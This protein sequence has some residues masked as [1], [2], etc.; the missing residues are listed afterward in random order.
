VIVGEL[1][2]IQ[3]TIE[4]DDDLVVHG[5]VEGT[6]RVGGAITV[7]PGAWVLAEVS[8]REVIV[9]GTVRGNVSAR[10]G[11][12]VTRT[13]RMIGDATAPRVTIAA[14]AGFRGRVEMGDLSGADE[15]PPLRAAAPAVVAVQQPPAATQPVRAATQQAARP[16][17]PLARPRT[18]LRRRSEP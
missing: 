16:V 10:E 11:I 18:T 12:E 1:I 5:R 3:G 4:G 17:P 8:A 2:R 14:G 15:P 9:H 6:V 7:E 13:G